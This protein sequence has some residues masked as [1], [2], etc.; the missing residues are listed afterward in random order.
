MKEQRNEDLALHVFITLVLN[1]V[2]GQLYFSAT[3]PLSTEHLVQ[4][5]SKVRPPEPFWIW[6]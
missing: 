5:E 2:D 4:R 3:L 1:G 6:S